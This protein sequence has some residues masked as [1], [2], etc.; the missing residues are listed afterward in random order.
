MRCGFRKKS[1]ARF[2]PCWRRLRRS[3]TPLSTFREGWPSS[4]AGLLL[5]CECC[6]SVGNFGDTRSRG[7]HWASAAGRRFTKNDRPVNPVAEPYNFVAGSAI[8]SAAGAE[9]SIRVARS[10]ARPG[11]VFS[12]WNSGSCGIELTLLPLDSADERGD[13]HHSAVHGAGLGAVLYGG[14]RGAGKKTVAAQK[15]GGGTSRRGLRARGR[16]RRLWR[17]PHG[18]GR[19]HRCVAGRIFLCVL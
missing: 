1:T 13:G 15:R 19:C 6:L 2:P 14:T 17:L 11:A 3:L 7:V 10:G 12:A 9:R 5:Y 18:H 16:Y 4:A 8:T